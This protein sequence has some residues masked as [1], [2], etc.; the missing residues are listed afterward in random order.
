MFEGLKRL[1][2][3]RDGLPKVPFM[4][5]DMSRIMNKLS[6]D[7]E[8]L[9]A[10][11]ETANRLHADACLLAIEGGAEEA[12]ARDKAQINFSKAERALADARAAITAAERRK[13]VDDEKAVAKALAEKQKRIASLQKQTLATC[14]MMDETMDQ[15]A[16]QAITL[17][18]QTKDLRLAGIKTAQEPIINL[19]RALGSRLRRTNIPLGRGHPFDEDALKLADLCPDLK[20]VIDA[21]G[22]KK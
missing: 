11:Y 8:T 3:D 4:K 18:D 20:S 16:E 2:T 17:R 5:Q 9:E 21:T 12:K 1:T 22:K 13:T 6:A 14:K 10:D 19:N 15:L 7:I